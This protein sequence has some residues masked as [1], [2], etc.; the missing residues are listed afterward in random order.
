MKAIILT[1]AMMILV[2][3]NQVS[4]NPDS[5]VSSAPKQVEFSAAVNL[6][7]G[8]V[9]AFRYEKAPS[10][11]VALKIYNENDI[12]VF[13]RRV[14]KI[15]GLELNCDMSQMEKGSYTAVVEKNGR[16]V[17]RKLIVLN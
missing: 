11:K 16:E 17:I 14:K 9:I 7:A 5:T 6:E 2:A 8:N 10:D 3:A 1:A 12:R 13:H 4:A 15:N